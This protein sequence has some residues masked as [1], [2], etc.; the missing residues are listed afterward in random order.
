VH[1]FGTVLKLADSGEGPPGKGEQKRKDDKEKERG[2]R[3]VKRKGEENRKELAP[4]DLRSQNHVPTPLALSSM[5]HIITDTHK[6]T[7][8]LSYSKF[9]QIL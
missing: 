8:N 9:C 6:S 7:N 1:E 4:I 5:K 2:G 3:V